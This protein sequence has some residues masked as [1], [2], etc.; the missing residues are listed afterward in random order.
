MQLFNSTSFLLGKMSGNWNN[1]NPTA[2][3]KNLM[4]YEFETGFHRSLSEISECSPVKD[5]N[6]EQ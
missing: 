2:N 4:S 6:S 3:D 1:E 5:Q